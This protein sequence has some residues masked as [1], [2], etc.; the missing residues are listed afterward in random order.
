MNKKVTF[1]T[2]ML[3]LGI[4]SII[5]SLLIHNEEYKAISG[6][7]IG[8]GAGFVGMSIANLI[9]VHI[10]K[11]HPE[12]KRQSD[13][14]LK[15]ERNVLI[16]CRAKAK[17]GDITQ[18]LIIGIAYITILISASLWVTLAVVLVFLIYHILGLYFISKYQREM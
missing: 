15:D 11:K 18:W 4:I 13:I 8:I 9:L 3:F 14:E 2:A 6:L 10:E 1:Y 5:I 7:L 17:A 12:S 16:R